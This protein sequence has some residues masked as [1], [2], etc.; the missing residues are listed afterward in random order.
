MSNAQKPNKKLRTKS[1]NKTGRA[2]KRAK[3][4]GRLRHGKG[5]NALRRKSSSTKRRK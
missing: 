5:K 2:G 4:K 1:N 3:A